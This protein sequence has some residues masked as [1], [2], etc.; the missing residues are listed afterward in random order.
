MAVPFEF[1]VAFPKS[2]TCARSAGPGCEGIGQRRIV[3]E[4]IASHGVEAV[5]ALAKLVA[6]G[7]E[8]IR[9]VERRIHVQA[10]PKRGSSPGWAR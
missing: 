1:I 6:F 3:V 8:T 10:I 7:G 4:E 9:H 2:G 5:V